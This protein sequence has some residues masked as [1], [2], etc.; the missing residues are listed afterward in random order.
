[1]INLS[2]MTK[3][4]IDS[5]EMLTAARGIREGQKYVNL[6]W[7]AGFKAVYADRQNKP[8][9]IS[10][11]NMV[12]PDD[13][14]VH[15]ITDYLDRE[16]SPDTVYGKKVILDLVCRDSE[17]NIFS[18]EVQRLL[19]R[20]FFKRCVY[21]G[22]RHY[23]NQLRRGQKYGTLNPVYVIA[24]LEEKIVHEDESLWD[25]DNLISCYRFAERRTNEEAD[26]TIM[27]T[28][29]ELG[30]FTKRACE[31]STERD[32]VFYWFKH[33]WMSDFLPEYPDGGSG[34]VT[35]LVRATEIA[36]FSPEKKAIYDSDIMNELDIIN[37]QQI[38]Y[39]QGL[40]EGVQK[41]REEER[42]EVAKKLLDKMDI[43]EISGITGLSRERVRELASLQQALA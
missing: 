32:K 25:S 10:L 30:R 20:H 31:C 24:F 41:G 8:L 19:D 16:Q 23:S 5:P 36:A 17:G 29:A 15:D 43:D 37:N 28:F 26:S 42:E 33:S 3:Q 18:V 38:L 40:A 39:E 12:L 35:E 2:K 14:R 1:M 27:I 6:M 13:V 9:L 21:Y 7:D 34:T 4:K 11:L 22:S